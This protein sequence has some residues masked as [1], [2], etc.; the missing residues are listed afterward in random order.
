MR[1]I[2]RQSHFGALLVAGVTLATGCADGRSEPMAEIAADS[3]IT[4]SL[5]EP[6]D[7]EPADSLDPL[8]GFDLDP[9]ATSSSQQQRV[10]LRLRNDGEEDALV[11]ADG[12]SGEVLID[13]VTAGSWTRVDVLTRASKIVLR[14]A[15]PTG[16]SLRRIEIETDLDML[17]EVVIQA[18]ANFP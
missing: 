5:T 6:P 9:P 16:R 3:S 10:A 11:F 8:Y 4:G 18:E 7:P 14:S 17:R 13:S 1:G 12:G 15:T 2:G